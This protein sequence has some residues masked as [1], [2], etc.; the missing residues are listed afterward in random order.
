MLKGAVNFCLTVTIAIAHLSS[1]AQK[2]AGIAKSSAKFVHCDR[3]G[4]AKNL[5]LMVLLHG[6]SGPSAFYS[7]QARFF[8][9]HGF[10][11]VLPHYL[12]AGHGPNA[13]DE[14]YETWVA[15][16]RKVIDESESNDNQRPATVIVGYSLGASVALAL[17]SQGQGPDAIAEQYGSLPDKFFRDM[18]GMP[19]LL[20]LHG[21]LDDIIPVDNALRL[22]RLCSVSDLKCDMYIYSTEGHGFSSKDQ[23]DANERILQFFAPI[24][25][26]RSQPTVH[27]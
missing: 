11:V 16:I 15:V 9:A 20:I 27:R 2:K 18:K 25:S 12:E 23:Q 10:R 13:T 22:F 6:A 19:P 4:N 3:F 24:V 17:G 14:N 7:D 26:V 5:P 21:E 8:A 1:G